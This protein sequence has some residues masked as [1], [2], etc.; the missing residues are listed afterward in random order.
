[1]NNSK[2]LCTVEFTYDQEVPEYQ[3]KYLEQLFMVLRNEVVDL[4]NP[5]YE[6][7]NAEYD[8]DVTGADDMDYNGFI[9]EKHREVMKEF[10][11]KYKAINHVMYM[12]SDE[13][14]D[15]VGV[16]PLYNYAVMHMSMRL[17]NEKEWREYHKT[18]KEA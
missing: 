5:N 7:W 16:I 18:H 2:L 15:I 10:N 4:I 14:A 6:K 17:I 3:K 13:Y 9:Q 8:K 12:D 1:M 11:K